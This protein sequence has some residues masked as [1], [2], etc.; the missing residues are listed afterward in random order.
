MYIVLQMYIDLINNYACRPIMFATCMTKLILWTRKTQWTTS[1]KL[2]KS[3]ALNSTIHG[4]EILCQT[5]P[6]HGEL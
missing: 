1:N 4:T 5:A 3:A 2:N 6:D